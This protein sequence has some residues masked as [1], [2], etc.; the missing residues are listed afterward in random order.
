MARVIAGSCPT[1]PLLAPMGRFAAATDRLDVMLFAVM[2]MSPALQQ[3]YNLLDDKQRPVSTGRCA[4][5]GALAPSASNRR[6]RNPERG[7]ATALRL[8]PKTT[9]W[10][11]LAA[12]TIAPHFKA[13]AVTN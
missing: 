11:P 1:D 5:S 4:K 8:H 9:P 12:G 13:D 6:P 2:S 10:P 7:G 3:L